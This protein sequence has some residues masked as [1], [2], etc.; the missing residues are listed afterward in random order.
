LRRAIAAL[1]DGTDDR[2]RRRH[3]GN[4]AASQDDAQPVELDYLARNKAAWEA[5]APEYTATG[6]AAWAADDLR[7]GIWEVP[8][9]ELALLENLPAGGDVIELGC[10]TAA[11][12]AWLARRGFRPVGVDFSRTQLET[13]ARFER[14][15]NVWFPLLCANAEELHYAEDSFDCA[16]SEYGV[17]L[18]SNPRRWLPEAARILRP[19]GL[20]VFVTNG[21]LLMTCTP[22]DGEQ[23]RDFLV[24]DYFGRYRIEFPGDGTVEFH[25][26]HGHWVRLL[27]SNGF[28]LESLIETRPPAGA[29]PRFPF[30]SAEWAQ[31]WPSEEIWV[32]RKE[33]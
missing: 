28:V 13:A 18:F 31:R 5:W 9:S 15:F 20:L 26:T 29:K 10:G 1:E 6:R 21:A 22:A 23:A 3:H 32:A 7:W 17:S 19:G 2:R 4:R 8:E 16:I 30:A 14:E 24:R 25:L 12:S 27:R 11:I 33:G